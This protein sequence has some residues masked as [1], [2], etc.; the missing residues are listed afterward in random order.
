MTTILLDPTLRRARI[1]RATVAVLLLA[2]VGATALC[3][4][5]LRARERPAP[6]LPSP[7]RGSKSA[8]RRPYF[9]QRP[10]AGQPRRLRKPSIDASSAADLVLDRRPPHVTAFIDPTVSGALTSLR[11]H[12]SQI[13]AAAFTGLLLGEDGRVVDRLDH[14]AVQVAR[15]AHVPA[16]ALV[17]N[18]DEHD[19]AWR[20]DR[21]RALAADAAARRQLGVALANTCAAAHLTGVHLDLEELGEDWQPLVTVGDEIGAALHARGL[22]LSVDVPASLD[23]DVLAAIGRVADRVVVMAYDE[24]DAD[25]PP[26]AIASDAFVADTIGLAARA[27]PAGKLAAGLPIYGYDWTG[28]DAAAPISFVDA[29]AAAREARVEPRW[30]HE[31]NVRFQYVDDEGTHQIWL[32]DASSVWNHARAAATAGVHD[33][34]LWRLGGEDPGVWDALAHL[35]DA[36]PPLG[37]VPADDRVTNEGD[38]PFLSLALAPTAGRRTI[39]IEGG[40]IVDE[41]WAVSPSPYLVRRAGIVPG[42]VALTFDDGPDPQ[43]TPRVLDVLAREHVPATF[44]VI[45]TS[46]AATPALLARMDA[47]GHEIGNHTFSH[48]DVDSVGELRLRSELESTTQIVASIIGRRP[49][50]YRPPSLADVEPRTAASAAAFA[51]AG[52]LG[53]LVVDADVDPRDWSQ[54]RSRAIVDDTLA[55]AEHGGVILLHDGG[56]DRSAT[57]EALPAIIA[58]LRARG[59]RFVALSDLVGKS[60]DEVMPR[61]ATPPIA[62][63]LVR[64]LLAANGV[65]R[66]VLA[67]VLVLLVGRA[68]FMVTAAAVGQ[69]RR[70]PARARGPLPPVTAVIPAFNEGAVI[71]RTIDSVLASDVPVDVVVVDDGSNDDTAEIVARR[72]RRERRVQL[73]RQPNGGK[74]AALRTGVAACRTE[75]VVA[76]DADTLFAPTTIRRLVEPMRDPRVGAVAG[77]AEVGNVENVWARWQAV[78][79][80]TQ[81]ELERRAWDA[82]GVVP[83]VPGAVGAWRRR[84]LIDAG[85]FSS[86]TL[87]EDAD[88]AMALCRRGWRVLHAPDARARTEVPASRRELVKQRVR[89]SFGVLQALWKH[90]RAPL[91]GRAGAFGR[92]VWPAMLLFLVALPLAA[93]AALLALALAAAAHNYTPAVAA[94]VILAVVELV[95]FAIACVWARRAGD[96][97]AIRLWP[98][99]LAARVFYRPILWWIALRS[100][101]RLADGVPLGWGKLARRN[102]AVAYAVATAQARAANG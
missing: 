70:R 48:P 98:S 34:A 43:F 59:L 18:L 80:L 82:L 87:A 81:Q 65:I 24:H 16:L 71:T 57:V 64:G 38:G 41:S 69:R 22:T 56:G 101:V 15:D 4:V 20:P 74:A 13:S 62:G 7:R 11:T 50:L 95:Q 32:T 3:A 53:Y 40:R 88:L 86:D 85:G 2:A 28:E 102:T 10:A 54:R 8:G 1:V 19:G 30:D 99:L 42:A 55:Q 58:G 33:V 93:P 91:E 60:R 45:G 52:T 75:V 44:F 31:G 96:V 68:L 12:A 51:R 78:E 14:A 100:I 67:V 9:G 25:G 61:V 39:R 66:V 92:V 26:G 49:L 63:R 36:L 94:S 90:R 77:T 5:E 84:A 37:S 83:I 21:V 23:G 17:Q 29:H 27:L 89:W 72:Y 46:A 47:E 97:A 73:L 6:T 76:L 79:Y 35:A